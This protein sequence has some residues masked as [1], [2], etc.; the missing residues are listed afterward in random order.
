MIPIAGQII[1]A[2]LGEPLLSDPHRILGVSIANDA[3]WLIALPRSTLPGRSK[4]HY[5]VGPRRCGLAEISGAIERGQLVMEDVPLPGTWLMT[6]ADYLRDAHNPG[7][8]KRRESRLKIR[9]ER[10]RAIE[11][12]VGKHVAN[13]IVSVM[14]I[15]RAQ[16]LAQAKEHEVSVPTVYSWLHRYLAGRGCQNSLLPNTDR[17]GNPGQRKARSNR[18]LGRKSRL[19]KE[20]LIETEG[21]LLKDGDPERLA[22]GY[23]MVKPGVTVR[24]AYLL[25]MGAFWSR[26]TQSKHGRVGTELL[27]IHERPTQ[28]QFEY[29]GRELHGDP[30]R[31]RM[32]GIE[33]WQTSTLEVTGCA[34]DQVHA[35]GQMA[36]IDS[37]STDVY[38]TSMMSRLKILPPMHRTIVKDVRSTMLLGFYLGWENPS[39]ETSLQAILCAA[40]DKRDFAARFGIE[41]EEDQWPG[42]LARHF[43]ADNGE[44]KSEA[45]KEAER[46]FRFGAEFVKAYSGQSKSQVENQ[47]HT[48]HKALDH[49]LPGT[50]RGKQRQRGELQPAT[51][52]L[53]NYREYVREFILS[54]LAYNN[55]EVAEL[56][57]TDMKLAGVVPTRANIFRWLRDHNMRADIPCDLDLLR[58][59]TLPNHPAVLRRDGIH[60]IMSNGIRQL[61]GHRFF[62]EELTR[63][64]RWH[65]AVRRNRGINVSVKLDAQDLHHVWL[66]TS[67][68]L[69]KIP[70]VMAEQILLDGLTLTDWMVHQ[71]TEDLR[72]DQARQANDQEG[73]D[74]VVRRADISHQAR[75]E[76]ASEE[77]LFSKKRS[78]K[79]R[80][81][82]LRKNKQDEQNLLNPSATAQ[83]AVVDSAETLGGVTKHEDAAALAMKAFNGGREA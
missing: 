47:H 14:P 45:M 25:T 56:A 75:L 43:L 79:A 54:A 65:Q 18:R 1:R 40:S 77:S 39:S 8:R 44:V 28:A 55:Q 78:R 24:D 76:R 51:Q 58:T 12:I 46:Q 10:W 23:A 19:A 82:Q 72:A 30:L 21:Y 68:G 29:W 52:A 5:M 71:S 63:D 41:L 59:F 50:T 36:M 83:Y 48:D 15:L 7:E 34:Q 80:P 17:C 53:W 20:G 27:P 42:M 66:P 22:Q 81:G 33:R 13:E 9:D 57:P 38:L 31:R 61:P 32:M 16:I 35:V 37:T 26:S 3:V 4:K 67:A 6:D 70:N 60:L 11:S 69:L 73:L 74:T 62:T 64:D 49:K 2:G